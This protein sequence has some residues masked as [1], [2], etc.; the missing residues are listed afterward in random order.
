MKGADGA[1][2]RQ[3]IKPGAGGGT[4]FLIMFQRKIG[5]IA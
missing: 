2:P 4:V 3:S 1:N 5:K